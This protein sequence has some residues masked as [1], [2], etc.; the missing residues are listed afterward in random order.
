MI[1]QSTDCFY[2]CEPILG[3]FQVPGSPTKIEGVPV[4]ADYCDNWFEAC[5]DDR[6]CV[7]HWG[8][9]FVYNEYFAN[10]CPN[11]PRASCRTFEDVYGISVLETE[12]FTQLTVK[13]VQ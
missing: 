12:C 11:D 1:F 6:T 9:D 4:C 8:E 5:K 13:T 3:H 7:E 10:S 2:F